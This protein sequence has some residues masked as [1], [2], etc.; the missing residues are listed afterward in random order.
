MHVGENNILKAHPQ[1]Q[2][3]SWQLKGFHLKSSFHSQGI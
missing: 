2:D 1:V 3:H